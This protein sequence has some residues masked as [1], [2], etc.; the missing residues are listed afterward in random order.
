MFA[1]ELESVSCALWSG[2]AVVFFRSKN[3]HRDE[4]LNF[5]VQKD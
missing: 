2:T 5:I 4:K 3:P 1:R